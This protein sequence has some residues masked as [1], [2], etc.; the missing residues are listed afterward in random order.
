MSCQ[1]RTIASLIDIDSVKKHLFSLV[2]AEPDD[3]WEWPDEDS[4]K[5]N[6][7]ET[8]WL[9]EC[10]ISLSST[11]QLLVIAHKKV[12]VVLTSKWDSQEQGDVKMKYHITWHGNPCKDENEQITSVLCLPLI[13]QGKSSHCGPDWT[14]IV[15]GLSSGFVQFYTENCNLLLSELLH[16]EPVTHLKC[17]SFEPRRFS[18][19]QEHSEELYVMYHSAVC[20]LM[21]FGL[22]PKLRA[23]RNQLARVKANCKAVMSASPLTY[24]KWGFTEQNVV[25][26]SEVVGP[27]TN[28]TFDHL[29]TASLCGGFNTYRSSAPQTSLILAVG[30]RPYVGFHYALEGEAPPMFAGVTKAVVSKVK[31]AFGQVVP[32]W[33]GGGKQNSSLE[34]DKKNVPIEPAVSMVCRFGLCDL[35]RHGDRL[36]MSPNRN[37]SVVS[38]SLGRI[39]LIDNLRGLAVRMWKGY[40]DAQC[41]W[42]E[43]QEETGRGGVSSRSAPLP[44]TALFLVIYEPKQGVIEIW[45]M[46]QGPRVAKFTASKSGRLLHMGHGFMGLDNNPLE[47]G[48]KSQFSCVFVDPGGLIKEI[49]VPFH[50]ALSDKNSKRTRDLHL[51]KKLKAFLK[52]NDY[53]NDRLIE[54][55]Q[56][57]MQELKTNDIRTQA[58]DML[59]TS[60]YITPDALEVALNIVVDKLTSQDAESVDHSS[61]TLLHMAQQLQRLVSFY[62]FIRREHQIPPTYSTVVADNLNSPQSLSILLH[63]PEKEVN[64]LRKLVATIESVALKTKSESEPRVAFR[65]DGKTAFVEFLSCFEVGGPSQESSTISLKE[66]ISEDKLKRNSEMVYQGT[67]YSDTKVEDWKKAAAKSHI[68]P[69]HLMQLALHFWLQKREGAALEAEM[70]RFTELL[71]AICSLTDVNVICAEYNG[72]SSWWRDVRRILTDST[73]PFMALTAAIVCRAV[74]LSVEKVKESNVLAHDISMPNGGPGDAVSL[75]QESSAVSPDDETHSSTSEW[76]NVSHDTCQWSLLIGQL[77]DVALLDSVLRQKPTPVE[78][79]AVPVSGRPQLFC[80]P[81]SRP[82]VSLSY[83]LNKGKGSVSELVARWLSSAGLDPDRLVDLSDVEFDNLEE[84]ERHPEE[85]SFRKAASLDIKEGSKLEVE[86]CAEAVPANEH[87]SNILG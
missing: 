17:Q 22:F 15:I 82:A 54:E 6:G 10:C 49:S 72:L 62:Q 36:V 61:K 23:C 76:E 20:V 73:N 58:I 30:K 77:E 41:G 25:A 31:A 12:M 29:V 55:V 64:G 2:E 87:E 60:K 7:K 74:A 27:A 48:N 51:L 57:R 9:Q 5:S 78:G 16:N 35:L 63:A 42:L 71:K 11:G 13:F 43:V 8:A 75:Q 84:R 28:N 4:L 47:G 80:C 39:I 79:G 45:A 3:S 52:E 85:G 66:N 32:S 14:C 46:Q 19:A 1:I 69:A 38:D 67:L 70:L 26:D 50:F 24:K 33:I 40:R 34:K 81:Y 83:L 86:Q 68:E 21:G 65:E 18:T 37:L 56:K 44:R 53:D 59:S